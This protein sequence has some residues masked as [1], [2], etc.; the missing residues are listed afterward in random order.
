MTNITPIRIKINTEMNKKTGKRPGIPT[1]RT[2]TIF[3]RDNLDSKFREFCFRNEPFSASD[4]S[5]C[6]G[7]TEAHTA[8]PHT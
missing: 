6:C 1:L 8:H 7:L 2:N 3:L 5:P 4:G